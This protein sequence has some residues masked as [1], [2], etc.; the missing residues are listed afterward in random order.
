TMAAQGGVKFWD[1]RTGAAKFSVAARASLS[2]C[3]FTRDGRRFAAP[4]TDGVQIFDVETGQTNSPVFP[5]ASPVTAVRFNSDGMLLFVACE[6]S[7]IAIL[8]VAEA[9]LVADW[10]SHRNSLDFLKLSPDGHTLAAL[11]EGEIRFWDTERRQMSASLPVQSGIIYEPEFSPDSRWLVTYGFD[12]PARLWNVRNGQAIGAPMHHRGGIARARFSPD[13]TRVA[14]ASFDATARVWDAP[15]G[16]PASP[17]LRHVGFV[18]ALD[19][20][21]DSRRLVT[22]GQDA[23]D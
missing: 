1:A 12:Q 17:L 23:T 22:T 19:F 15:T 20:S 7:R 4:V 11:S 18:L 13:G 9:R 16:E 2:A 14:T 3:Q 8:N 21:P 10:L 5:T 6:N